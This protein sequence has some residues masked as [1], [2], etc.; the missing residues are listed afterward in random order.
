[1]A[2]LEANWS[3]DGEA[4][5]EAAGVGWQIR[6]FGGASGA[7]SYRDAGAAVMLAVH[8]PLLLALVAQA[9]P[10]SYGELPQGKTCENCCSASERG[11]RSSRR[12]VGDL[13]EGE[14]VPSDRSERGRSDAAL[15]SC[16]SQSGVEGSPGL[17]L[18][19]EEACDVVIE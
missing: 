3:C 15:K 17:C 5:W 9:T 16:G 4:G 1:M 11:L 2:M 6:A 7:G 8:V 10:H 18:W 14:A 13:W 12:G 19:L